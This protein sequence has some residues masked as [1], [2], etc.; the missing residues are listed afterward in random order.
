[1]HGGGLHPPFIR[2]S[3]PPLTS[4]NQR[5]AP[6]RPRLLKAIGDSHAIAAVRCSPSHIKEGRLEQ[7]A[8]LLLRVH[9]AVDQIPAGAVHV[10]EER[11]GI[12]PLAHLLGVR[13]E[14]RHVTHVHV[15]DQ[16]LDG[17]RIR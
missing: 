3:K 4:P 16:A 5:L 14:G 6:Q 9:E 2:T 17:G 1:M 15:N 12:G 13:A 8:A 10:A 7:R 11:H